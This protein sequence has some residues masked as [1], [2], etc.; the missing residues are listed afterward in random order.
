MQRAN[1]RPSTANDQRM[2]NIYIGLNALQSHFRIII[3]CVFFLVTYTI[4]VVNINVNVDSWQWKERKNELLLLSF[5]LVTLYILVPMW[6]SQCISLALELVVL[7][8]FEILS[9]P[10]CSN[11]ISISAWLHE[12]RF[13]WF[14]CYE[15][16]VLG[17]SQLTEPSLA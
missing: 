9:E 12:I 17:W 8:H 6:P 11:I 7:E 4:V 2:K 14:V 5:L 16:W 1:S 3:W 10:I 15:Y 13:F